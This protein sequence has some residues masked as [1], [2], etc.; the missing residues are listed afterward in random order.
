MEPLQQEQFRVSALSQ[1][2]HLAQGRLQMW[3][4]HVGRVLPAL[5]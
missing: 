2:D 1:T 3:W 4:G 5:E